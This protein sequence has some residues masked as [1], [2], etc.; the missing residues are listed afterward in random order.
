[1]HKSYIWNIIKMSFHGK[2]IRIML[3]EY[4]FFEKDTRT[5]TS[6]SNSVPRDSFPLLQSSGFPESVFPNL[7]VYSSLFES[8]SLLLPSLS[9]FLS[10]AGCNRRETP[11]SR[12]GQG[13]Y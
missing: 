4:I 3:G 8:I 11:C 1:M 13:Q 6:V 2:C 5:T 7:P 10:K 9:S 12:G